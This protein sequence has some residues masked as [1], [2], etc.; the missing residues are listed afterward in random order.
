[1]YVLWYF[2]M[3]I[4]TIFDWNKNHFSFFSTDDKATA[5]A[6]ASWSTGQIDKKP[7]PRILSCRTASENTFSSHRFRESFLVASLPGILSRC[8]AS[9]NNIFYQTVLLPNGL[10]WCVWGTS[11]NYND[12]GISNSSIIVKYVANHNALCEIFCFPNRFRHTPS[13]MMF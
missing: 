4:F 3:L 8:T 9:E 5:K 13:H 1:M 10:Y 7:L 6:F 11:Q 12:A 2:I